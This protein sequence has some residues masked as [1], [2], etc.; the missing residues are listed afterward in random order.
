M[1]ETW[2]GGTYWWWII[3]IMCLKYLTTD[4]DDAR[5]GGYK[6]WD[7]WTRTRM[8]SEFSLIY[9]LIVYLLWYLSNRGW[10]GYCDILCLKSF[11]MVVLQLL[12]TSC[13]YRDNC[14]PKL[15]AH[16]S[17]FLYLYMVFFQHF[18]HLEQH[19]FHL[20]R[21]FSCSTNIPNL[22]SRFLNS[23]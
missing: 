19:C 21:Q 8:Y 3:E 13:W 4:L 1:D 11:C 22:L 18:F 10:K 17:Y 12:G 15:W 20:D 2:V 7:W 14:I 9:F 6:F 16:R 5:V 23:I